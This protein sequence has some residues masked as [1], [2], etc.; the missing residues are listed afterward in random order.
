MK[1]IA[2]YSYKGGTGR[3]LAL[4]NAARYLARLE[5]RVVALDLD[6]EAPGLHY[7]FS[8]NSDGSALSVDKGIVDY[9][10]SFIYSGRP[11]ESLGPYSVDVLV[12][13]VEHCLTLIPAGSL[14]S[15]SYW[16]KLSGIDWHNLFYSPTSMGVEIF[17]EFKSR[18]EDELNPDFLLIDSRTGITEMGGVATTLLAD[19]AICVVLPTRENLDGARVVLQSM[20][21][22]RRENGQ[23]ELD[24]M[25]ALSRVTQF[26]NPDDEGARVKRV[27]EI[28]SEPALEPHD[29][30]ECPEVFV[31]HHEAGLEI[32]DALRVGSGMSPDDSVLLRDYLRLF[33]KV[34]PAQSVA[35][36]VEALIQAAK[37]KVWDG[38]EGPDV[39]Q[40]ELE[41]LAESFGRSEIYRA[42]LHM[43]TLR[44]VSGPL[45]LRTAQR[46]WDITVD[47]A[48]GL[49][50]QIVKKEFRPSPSRQRDG[51]TPRVEFIEAIWRKAGQR[52]PEFAVRF[53]DALAMQTKVS[54][55]A[56]LLLE[57]V[58]NASWTP[59]VLTGAVRMLD[60]A[61]RFTEADRL[62][63]DNREL[64][65]KD[66]N[67]ADVWVQHALHS[68]DS[69]MLL[70]MTE[71]PGSVLGKV[72]P[73]LAAHVYGR[74]NMTDEAKAIADDALR[75][76]RAHGYP[77]W[78][79]TDLG[80]L[81]EQ[82]GRWEDFEQIATQVSPL[83]ADEFR[84]R[85][86]KRRREL[87]NE[88][89]TRTG[90]ED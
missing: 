38:P 73:A 27:R 28:L 57:V 35:S 39:A 15:K 10:S 54:H 62:I 90:K 25:V 87:S 53:A 6:L 79:L 14:P 7:K 58:N 74:L 69:K 32:Q 44:N 20:Q 3:S 26:E 52:D 59:A 43:Y 37:N 4:A 34:V 55:A 45:M 9:I 5:F 60:A 83:F 72:R 11:P 65:E 50:W 75:D 16:S 67:L 56:D 76:L 21:R 48:D 68:G 18:I 64:F 84:R 89:H 63:A 2:F 24:L 19:K 80:R 31:L 85:M 41:E 66:Q 17:M 86:S 30:I 42:L 88:W 23:D 33:A 46:L 70:A 29:T 13:G 47:S 81:F 12:P 82:I 61:R 22:T 40:K 51:W 36:K 78:G 49:L 71:P 8:T 77:Q 1:T